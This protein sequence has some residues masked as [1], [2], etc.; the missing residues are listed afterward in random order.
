MNAEELKAELR[1]I[2]GSQVEFNKE[3]DKQAEE[4][5]NIDSTLI[6]WCTL[7]KEGKIRA[8]RPPK[9]LD[10]VVFINKIGSSSRC[11]IIKITGGEFKEV[12]LGD[13]AY[14]DKLRRIIGLKKDSKKY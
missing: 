1:E 14:C 9:L 3:F 6:E 7:V 13:H 2:F 10:G 12:H 11:I 5:K 8:I 4:I